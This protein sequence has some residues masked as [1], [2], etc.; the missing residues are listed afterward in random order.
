MDARRWD[1]RKQR[2]IWANR[3][4]L[5]DNTCTHFNM[6]SVAVVFL[7]K[8]TVTCMLLDMS[9]LIFSPANKS[10]VSAMWTAWPNSCSRH[11]AELLQS[12]IFLKQDTVFWTVFRTLMHMPFV[13]VKHI[14]YCLSTPP[15][16][17]G[18]F[19]FPHTQ[20]DMIIEFEWG[21][22]FLRC[23]LQLVV[24]GKRDY[25]YLFW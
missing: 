10:A 25:T 4:R 2:Q 15:H 9:R 8:V 24:S 6:R 12:E 14:H 21:I 3:A 5:R 17:C 22:V 20:A 23:G 16:I 7:I 19:F 18:N 11:W 1:P 13:S